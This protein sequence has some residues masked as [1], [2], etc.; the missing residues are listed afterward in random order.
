MFFS[1][2]KFKKNLIAAWYSDFYQHNHE[3]GFKTDVLR[4]QN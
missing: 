1:E 4:L 3:Y 2:Y